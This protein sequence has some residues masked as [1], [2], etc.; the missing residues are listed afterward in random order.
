MNAAELAEFIRAN[1]TYGL[2]EVS[3]DAEHVYVVLG[4][5]LPGNRVGRYTF[6]VRHDPSPE[7][8]LE[9]LRIADADLVNPPTSGLPTWG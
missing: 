9:C 4:H 7:A 6:A 3:E 2:L 5:P 8:V 1:S